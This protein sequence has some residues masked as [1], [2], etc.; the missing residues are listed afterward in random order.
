MAKPMP[1]LAP[2]MNKVLPAKL[3]IVKSPCVL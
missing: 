3:P 1:R 2:L